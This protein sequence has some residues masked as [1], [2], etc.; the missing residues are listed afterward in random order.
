MA[1]LT[2]RNL[3]EALKSRLRVRAA[4]QG[5]SMEEEV[6]RI[7]RDALLPASDQKGLGSRVHRQIMTLSGG[8][9]LP[10]PTRSLPRSSPFSEPGAG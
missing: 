8:G 10:L 2:I 3:D 6:R 5:S 9:E 1:M 4:E 7:L